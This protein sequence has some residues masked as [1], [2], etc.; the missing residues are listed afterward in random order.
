MLAI[1]LES[2]S[3]HTIHSV[4]LS[5]VLK[6]HS[7]YLQDFQEYRKRLVASFEE[8]INECTELAGW[9][10]K[11]YLVLKDTVDKYHRKLHSVLKRYRTSLEEG[12][13]AFLFTPMRK[14][15]EAE[16]LNGFLDKTVGHFKKKE[17]NKKNLKKIKV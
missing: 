15:L 16:D 5:Q 10:S 17:D 3:L 2:G 8:E 11:N 9:K 4:M 12:L 14:S 7:Y 6:Y 1:L 13:E